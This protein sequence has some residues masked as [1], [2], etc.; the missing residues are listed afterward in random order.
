MTY[1]AKRFVSLRETFVFVS[2]GLGRLR[3]AKRKWRRRRVRLDRIDSKCCFRGASDR[4][5]AEDAKG[6]ETLQGGAKAHLT[7]EIIRARKLV[8]KAN[9]SPNADGS[10]P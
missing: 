4:V 7:I 2:R 9:M 8:R 5:F 3:S 1:A 10:A 6:C